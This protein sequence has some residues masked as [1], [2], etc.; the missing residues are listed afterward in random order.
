MSVKVRKQT[1][2]AATLELTNGKKYTYFPD[3]GSVASIINT[4][5]SY[6][7]KGKGVVKVYDES[8]A[9]LG[10]SL[11]A[12]VTIS[13]IYFSDAST[14]LIKMSPYTYETIE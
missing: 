2:I 9:V 10:A 14:D 12:L 5:A 6:D 1:E 4:I 11:Q 8:G 3:G 7:L 13:P